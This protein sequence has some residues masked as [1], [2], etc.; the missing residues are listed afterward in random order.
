[1][2]GLGMFSTEVD[3]SVVVY[4]P[5]AD[6]SAILSCRKSCIK[7]IAIAQKLNSPFLQGDKEINP[8]GKDMTQ[9]FV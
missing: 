6:P 1:M 5:V 9:L 4:L 7:P 2:P 3:D 8:S